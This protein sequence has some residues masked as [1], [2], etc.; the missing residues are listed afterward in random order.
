MNSQFAIN[1]AKARHQSGASLI[2][3]V[4]YLGVAAIV[5]IGAVMLLNTAFGGANV[6]RAIQ[7]ISGLQTAVKRLYMGQVTGYGTADLIP[8]L[9]QAQ[10]VPSTISIRNGTEL[11]NSWNGQITIEGVANTQFDVTYRNVP[12]GA[13]VELATSRGGTGF[14]EVEINGTVFTAF[15]L[16]VA[17]A[18]GNCNGPSN[19]IRW[20]S[21]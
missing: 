9:L 6:N 20:R 2:E 15:P 21:T 11:W 1:T 4:S 5:V 19:D 13:C 10:Q 17:D 3:I 16:T 12:Q 18:T 14:T 8:D 7:E